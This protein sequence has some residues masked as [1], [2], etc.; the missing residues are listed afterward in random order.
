VALGARLLR[1]VPRFR[2]AAPC[3]AAPAALVCLALLA[4][5]LPAQAGGRQQSSIL[6]DYET[7]EV[8]HAVEPDAPVF[9]AS[10]TKMM[11]LYLVFEAMEAG[12][13]APS[14]KLK[15]SARAAAM[16]PTKLGLKPGSSIKVEDAIMA[17]VTKSANDVAAAVG[18]SLGG[19]EARFAELMTEKARALGMTRTTFRNASGLP[20]DQQRSTARDLATLSTRLIT[21]FPKYYRFFGRKQHVFAGRTL[22][23]HNRLMR[24]YG[25]MDGIKTGYTNA[26]GF[27]LAASAVRD[28][29]RLVA[30]VV[31]GGSAASRDVQM[32]KLLD[33][34]FVQLAKRGTAKPAAPL[35][36]S[37]APPRAAADGSALD[38]A[39][40]AARTPVAKPEA[41]GAVAAAAATV[42]AAPGVD[43]LAALAA[44]AAAKAIVPSAEAAE[45]AEPAAVTRVA[46]APA[47]RPAAVAAPSKRRPAVATARAAKAAAATAKARGATARRPGGGK[48]VA[49]GVQ[50]GVF[51][52]VKEARRAAQT[53]LKAAPAQLRGTFVSVHTVKQGKRVLYRAQLH[54]LAR[55]DAQSAC[56]LIQ[57]RRQDC[58]VIQTS[59]LTVA[60]S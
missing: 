15:L 3:A 48:G 52:G 46:A 10:L 23:N 2:P 16:P 27:N 37:L 58:M 25:G 33:R 45:E 28:G 40:A 47:A 41:G 32:A 26:S 11:T 31:G 44:V 14:T 1:L 4:A 24:S 18:E 13:L 29:H 51:S 20:N 38:A 55:G 56:K 43:E 39:V 35:V 59:A 49:Y 17:L 8:L 7:G 12:R 50:V 21:D 19:S 42:A 34:G 57:K 6:L 30:V 22:G 36:A 54:G 53:A 9:P 5:P 60:S